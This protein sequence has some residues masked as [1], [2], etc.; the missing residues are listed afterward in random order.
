MHFNPASA[1]VVREIRLSNVGPIMAHSPLL[2]HETIRAADL[3]DKSQAWINV[4]R[5]LSQ[6]FRRLQHLTVHIVGQRSADDVRRMMDAWKAVIEKNCFTLESLVWDAGPTEFVVES[7]PFMASL[8]YFRSSTLGW[9]QPA[10][11]D[12]IQ[13][14]ILRVFEARVSRA[15]VYNR[16]LMM[17]TSLE[18]VSLSGYR[19][20]IMT[21]IRSLLVGRSR[22]M[23]RQIVVRTDSDLSDAM[24][25]LNSWRSLLN[26]QRL[27]KGIAALPPIS[28]IVVGAD[29]LASGRQQP[30][31]DRY[32]CG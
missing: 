24:A 21:A 5:D 12:D 6:A 1:S 31:W 27:R 17:Q 23:L 19:F 11:K 20:Q 15:D 4:K 26:E 18:F 7:F 2:F 10:Y 3:P 8:R 28:V 9:M 13:A 14:P 16:F 32:H 29:Y 25:Y 22:L 30:T